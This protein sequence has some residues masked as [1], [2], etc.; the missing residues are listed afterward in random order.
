MKRHGPEAVC[1]FE[2]WKVSSTDTGRRL[3]LSS[4]FAEWQNESV[5]SRNVDDILKLPAEKRLRLVEL[6][7]ESLVEG[8]SDVPLGEGHRAAIDERLAE[9]ERDPDDVVSRKEVL[10]RARDPEVVGDHLIET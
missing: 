10:N 3:A 4:L 5:N 9:H 1:V 6:I 8:P 2:R 7:W